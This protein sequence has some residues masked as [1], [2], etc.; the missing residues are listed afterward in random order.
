MAVPSTFVDEGAYVIILYSTA[1]KAL[2][3]PQLV[4][5]TQ[6]LLAFNKG[7]SQ[8]LVILPMFPITL[9]GKTIYIDMMVVQGPL[10][11]NIFLGCDYV[12][13]MGALIS[14]LF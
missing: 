4:P 3:S 9:G 14:Y 12:Y 1:W 2:G 11:F 10:D 8:P 6:N 13:V 5:I 7:T